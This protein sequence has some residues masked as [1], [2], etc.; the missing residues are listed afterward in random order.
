MELEYTTLREE[1]LQLMQKR[2][3]YTRFAY[4]ATAAIWT[5]ASAVENAYIVLLG[6]FILMPI[7]VRVTDILYSSGYIAAYLSV[8][9]ESKSKTDAKWETLNYEYRKEHNRKHNVMLRYISGRMDFV[10]L[11]VLN[12]GIFWVYRNA[13][14]FEHS[15]FDGVIIVIQFL[16]ILF[17]YYQCCRSAVAD[18]KRD[19]IIDNWKNIKRKL[20]G[21]EK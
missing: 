16:I 18:K 14:L 7:A 9:H 17:T 1:I 13:Q 11:Q 3:E 12:V 2:D 19:K 6:M 5:A 21:G 20:E 10:M 4:T 8:F 15:E